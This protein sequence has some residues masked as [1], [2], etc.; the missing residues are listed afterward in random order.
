[1]AR[2]LEPLFGS[3]ARY[4]MGVGLF[5][6]GISSALTAPLASAYALCGALGKSADLK[7]LHFRAVWLIIIAIGAVV[8]LQGFRPLR[9]IWFAQI[10]NGLLLPIITA[11]LLWAMNSRTRLGAYRNTWWQ[12][13]LGILVL[14]I[15]V[16][17]GG[18]SL[19]AALG[20]L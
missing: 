12:N 4:C 13:A 20:W 8:A 7:A 16:L 15:S 11:F 10:A 19:L 14:I 17:L 5:A 6:A 3:A 2:S 9:L 18:R 1:M